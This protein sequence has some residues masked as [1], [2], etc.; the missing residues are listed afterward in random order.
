MIVEYVTEAFRVRFPG[1]DPPIEL[2]G[3]VDRPKQESDR[4]GKPVVIFSHCFTCNKDFKATVRISRA[5]ART[6]ITVLRFDMRGLGGSKG[7]FSQSNFTSNLEDLDAAIRFAQA[8]LGE[9][10]GL[11]GHSFGGVASL[12]TAAKSAMSAMSSKE[13]APLSQLG[14]VITLAAPSDTHHLAKLLARMNP[15]IESVGQGEVTIG[16][17]RWMIQK[18]MLEDFRS[19]DATALLPHIQCPVMLMHSPED[20]TLAYDHALR[21]MNVITGVREPQAIGQPGHTSRS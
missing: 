18:Q 13:S 16:G 4:S 1:G 3:I 10:T 5:L 8:E 17:I 14:A 7:D 11:I 15:E 12:V 21:L 19:H 9:V 2:A 6:G 20:E